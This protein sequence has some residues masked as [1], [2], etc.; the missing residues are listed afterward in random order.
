[1]VF[2]TLLSFAEPSDI[3]PLFLSPPVLEPS[4]SL[5]GFSSSAPPTVAD[6]GS[7]GVVISGSVGS[8]TTTVPGEVM[9]LIETDGLTRKS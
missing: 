8:V 4:S 7:Y 5:I 2:Y 9:S 3:P 6:V 1:M